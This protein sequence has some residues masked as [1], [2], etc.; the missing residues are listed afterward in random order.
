M[1]HPQTAPHV[2][3]YLNPFKAAAAS[4]GMEA[5]VAPVDDLPEVEFL[6]STS[7]PNSG[8]LVMPD[9]FTES[10]LGEITAL[11][12]RY[13]VPAVNWSRSFTELG[14]LISYGPPWRSSD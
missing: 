14:G 13:R 6:I 2:Q 11:A 3:G 4:L 10:H 5:I 12:A 1:F 9:V 7:E 8:L